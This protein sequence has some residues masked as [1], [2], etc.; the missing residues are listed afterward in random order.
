LLAGATSNLGDE[1]E[2]ALTLALKM[3]ENTC[4]TAYGQTTGGIHGFFVLLSIV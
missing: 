1:A 3:L 4:G 2:F